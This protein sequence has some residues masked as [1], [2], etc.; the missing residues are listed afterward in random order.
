[1]HNGPFCHICGQENIEPRESFWHLVQHFVMDITHFDGKFFSTLKLLLT[2]PGFLSIEYMRGRRAS[3]LNPI[4]M[5]V[6]TS[7]LFFLIFFTIH[8]VGKTNEELKAKAET[9]QALDSLKQRKILLQD[10]LLKLTDSASIQQITK[11]ITT[12]E[13]AEKVVDL[14]GELSPA[15]EIDNDFDPNKNDTSEV[16]NN[17]EKT[18]NYNETNKGVVD[19]FA[20]LADKTKNLSSQI[21]KVMFLTLPLMALLL[22]LLYRKI[23]KYYYVDHLIFIVHLYIALYIIIL[24][25][26]AIGFLNTT[27]PNGLTNFL[28]SLASFGMFFYIYKSLRNFYGQGRVKTIFKFFLFN[29]FFVIIAITVTSFYLITQYFSTQH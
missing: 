3:Y 6:F 10:S 29:M 8:K 25:T 5:Y 20:F 27:W 28:S 15:I 18:K 1:M 26:E 16:K 14:F 19:F 21:P 9:K 7:A 23:K 13:N 17:A 12:T 24:L 22:K 4:K 2:K 11:E